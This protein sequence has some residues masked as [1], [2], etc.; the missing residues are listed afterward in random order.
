LSIHK[1]F[2]EV[3]HK[4]KEMKIKGKSHNTGEVIEMKRQVNGSGEIHCTGF[5]L[6]ELL[7]VI[8]IIAI[9]AAM[10]LPALQRARDQAIR[11]TC[12]NNMRQ[13]GLA[14]YMYANDYDGWFPPYIQEDGQVAEVA[15]DPP[16]HPGYDGKERHIFNM[17]VLTPEYIQNPA[18]LCCPGSVG[19]SG[20]WNSAAHPAGNTGLMFPAGPDK[21]GPGLGDMYDG[22]SVTYSYRP[23]LRIQDIGK[24]LSSYDVLM[25]DRFAA[26][27]DLTQHI[28]WREITWRFTSPV[29]P[30]L[31]DPDNPG[32]M[33]IFNH[34][35]YGINVLYVD[36]R[37]EWVAPDSKDGN[38]HYLPNDKLI[39]AHRPDVGEG[40]RHFGAVPWV[41]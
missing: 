9:L 24:T 37:V 20:H 39:G 19:M 31:L 3:R 21:G 36:G 26:G 18:I 6:I 41:Y 15:G 17:Y 2:K 27:G 13:I 32:R 14:L 22:R 23:G 5:T 40:L 28:P 33:A 12:M 11:S 4:M 16:G 35:L 38:Y 29:G 8:A 30:I 7:V 25:S 10:L 1:N 34:R